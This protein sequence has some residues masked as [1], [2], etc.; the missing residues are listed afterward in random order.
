MKHYLKTLENTVRNHWNL[1][2]LCPD[3]GYAPPKSIFG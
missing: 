1:K 3:F 2:A